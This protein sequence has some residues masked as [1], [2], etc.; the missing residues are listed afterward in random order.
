MLTVYI[1]P[2]RFKVA[3]EIDTGASAKSFA[4][5]ILR[6]W[7]IRDRNSNVSMLTYAKGA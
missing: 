3:H 4:P 1:F 6:K 7:A 5:E 2:R